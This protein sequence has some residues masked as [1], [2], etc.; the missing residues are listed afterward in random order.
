MGNCGHSDK[1]CKCCQLKIR[2]SED[3]LAAICILGKVWTF[4]A[5]S[6]KSSVNKLSD[7]QSKYLHSRDKIPL[8]PISKRRIYW[9]IQA[10]LFFLQEHHI[11]MKK[12]RSPK[13]LPC[14]KCGHMRWVVNGVLNLLIRYS[15]GRSWFTYTKTKKRSKGEFRKP[16]RPR[17]QWKKHKWRILWIRE[18]IQNLLPLI[19]SLKP[20]LLKFNHYSKK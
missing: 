5:A 20:K 4:T 14:W 16:K 8:F 12:Q 7:T 18:S 17:N 1:L 19:N 6:D 2:V 11:N 3:R 15:Q 10:N 9:E 13:L